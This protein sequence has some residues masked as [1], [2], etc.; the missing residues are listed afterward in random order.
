MVAKG[1][2]GEAAGASTPTVPAAA[3]PPDGL[4]KRP[5]RAEGAG[6]ALAETTEPVAEDDAPGGGAAAEAA[7]AVTK[8][9]A[10]EAS[11]PAD[12]GATVDALRK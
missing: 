7:S 2:S 11:L 3:E 1:M 9:T 6:G 10:E 8:K 4:G 12:P 5:E